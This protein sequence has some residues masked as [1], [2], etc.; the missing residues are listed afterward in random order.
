M[1]KVTHDI[2]L[3]IKNMPQGWVDAWRHY[4]YFKGRTNRSGFWSFAVINSLIA[5]AL[6]VISAQLGLI[7]GVQVHT[8]YLECY[9]L[10]TVYILL[11]M[12]P[13]FCLCIRRLHDLN[14][15]GAWFWVWFLVL[16]ATIPY[17]YVNFVCQ[18]FMLMVA[19]YPSSEK[20]RFGSP[21]KTCF[22]I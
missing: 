8:V 12:I 13:S 20:E 21:P 1:Q 19:C 17:L 5:Y 15:R 14:L 11:S 4:F 2:L 22:T 3:F 7:Y 18:W 9:L 6:F 10:F 16:F